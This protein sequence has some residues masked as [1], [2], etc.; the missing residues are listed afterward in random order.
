MIKFSNS[1]A[2]SEFMEPRNDVRF[3]V[4]RELSQV[5]SWDAFLASC[6]A[7]HFEQTS[8]WGAVKNIY[9][10]KPV[11]VWASRNGQIV[12]GAMI[13]TRRS[14][15][16]VK[17]G[18]VLRGPVWMP[19]DPE[20]LDLAVQALYRF[21][22]SA[23]STYL[24][25]VPPNDAE[26]LV[27]V[28]ESL[29]FHRKPD[30][31][32]P[33]GLDTAT[34]V[35]NLEKDLDSLFAAM[36]MT[37]RQNIRRGLRKGVKVRV[38][39]VTDA[40]TFRK[41]MFIACKRRGVRANPWQEDFFQQLWDKMGSAGTVK[42][43]MAEVEGEAVSGACAMIF[44]GRLQLWRVGWSGKFDKYDPNDVLH[45]EI[46]KWAKENGCKEFDFVHVPR[47]HARALL[48]GNKISDSYSGVTE[49]KMGFGGELRLLPEHF[50]RSFHPAVHSI[51]N[52]GVARI[53][54]S[55]AGQKVCRG[56][57]DKVLKEMP[58]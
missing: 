42:F 39:D 37:K 14:G 19:G 34:L 17:I 52:M 48:T 23:G 29:G 28:L 43:F 10:W 51:L 22:Q 6:P 40:D 31:F 5:A 46:I 12:G 50:Y 49:Y 26:N 20:S 7:A 45:W 55:L 21:A 35:I 32:P 11:W 47:S 27:P 4:C 2:E 25:V 44:G 18:Y 13:L 8:A 15:R 9:G 54:S 24:V 38:G 57:A 36:S 16:F 30:L 1:N 3:E 33:T 41:L 53:V 58:S 56:I